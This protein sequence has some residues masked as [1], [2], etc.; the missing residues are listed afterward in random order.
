MATELRDLKKQLSK[1]KEALD[2][3]NRALL[4][5]EAS[6]GQDCTEK[7]AVGGQTNL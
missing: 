4:K 3:A 5:Y 1:A 6:G 2:A 7:S